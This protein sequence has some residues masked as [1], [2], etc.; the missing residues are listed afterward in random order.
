M[1]MSTRL[2]V[3]FCLWTLIFYEKITYR[4]IKTVCKNL[5]MHNHQQIAGVTRTSLCLSNISFNSVFI[6]VLVGRQHDNAYN[7]L[8]HILQVFKNCFM[9]VFMW[10]SHKHSSC[11]KY[12][13]SDL[14][15]NYINVRIYHVQDKVDQCLYRSIF[16]ALKITKILIWTAAWWHHRVPKALEWW[17]EYNTTWCKKWLF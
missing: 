5:H 14:V 15:D 10:F 7:I 17:L 11:A 6:S 16:S 13:S 2:E 12:A 1:K 4:H 3:T 8:S 9:Y